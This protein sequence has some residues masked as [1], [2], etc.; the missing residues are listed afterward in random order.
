MKRRFFF[1]NIGIVAGAFIFGA[2]K[3]LAAPKDN[4]LCLANAL[5][6]AVNKHKSST[7]EEVV[8]HWIDSAPDGHYRYVTFD[9]LNCFPHRES[10]PYK[11]HYA[12]LSEFKY[13][14]YLDR[15]EHVKMFDYKNNGPVRVMVTNPNDFGPIAD[16]IR[17]KYNNSKKNCII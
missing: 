9:Y 2:D 16:L 7:D 3:A 17:D 5:K 6:D 11:K 14:K 1:K 10:V 8:Q 12:E 15:F 13:A 4:F